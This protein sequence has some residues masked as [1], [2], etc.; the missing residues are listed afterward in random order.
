MDTITKKNVYVLPW[1]IEGKIK[2][3]NITQ[4]L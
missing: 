3:M 4:N 2:Q 1:K